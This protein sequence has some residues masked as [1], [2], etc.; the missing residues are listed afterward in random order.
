MGALSAKCTEACPATTLNLMGDALGNEGLDGA[1]GSEQP[2]DNHVFKAQKKITDPLKKANDDLQHGAMRGELKRIERAI[3]AGG[4]IDSCNARGVTPL[5]LA[6][7]SL[8]KES[9]E[10]LKAIMDQKGEMAKEDHNGWTALH[11]ACRN[12]RNEHIKHLVSVSANLA[13]VTKDKKTCL[14]LAVIEGKVDLV[15]D[16]MKY[17]QCKQ[18][19]TEKDAFG[20]SALHYA[21]KDGSLDIVK[22]LLENMAKPDTKD[23]DWRTPLMVACEYGKLEVVKYLCK[24]SAQIDFQDKNQRTALMYACLNSYE[25]VALWLVQKRN[26]QPNIQDFQGDTP[27]GVAIDMGMTNFKNILKNRMT[28]VEDEG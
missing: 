5:M 18:S 2:G 19:V 15:R 25:G 28:E 21:S 10:V 26:A 23:V 11:H 9:M 3:K 14:M 13:A 1:A 16:L 7:A 27:L 6:S 12:G 17:K 4:N 8:G 24:K 22:H 20:Q